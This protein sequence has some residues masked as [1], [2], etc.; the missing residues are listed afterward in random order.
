MSVDR[1]M[2][3][4][5]REAIQR[6]KE[7]EKSQREREPD[8]E[9]IAD[10][11]QFKESS[12]N[13]LDNA[14]TQTKITVSQVSPEDAHKVAVASLSNTTFKRILRSMIGELLVDKQ[15]ITKI[16]F[17]I[18]NGEYPEF[19]E[20]YGMTKAHFEDITNGNFSRFDIVPDGKA[21]ALTFRTTQGNDALR[22]IEP[23]V[24]AQII[25]TIF[26]H[27]PESAPQQLQSNINTK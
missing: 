20:Q 6:D 8:F 5:Y 21:I 16:D 18:L 2:D 15:P 17:A 23:S 4:I 9:N 24:L 7:K 27:I 13:L 14:Q 1:T 10:K 26:S 11:E 19:E 12:E 3:A 25:N 22:T